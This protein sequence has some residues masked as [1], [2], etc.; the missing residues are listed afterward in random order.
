[1]LLSLPMYPA[2]P[3]S[4]V[5]DMPLEPVMEPPDMLEQ[6]ERSATMAAVKKSLVMKRFLAGRLKSG[7][8]GC[9]AKM[10]AVIDTCLASRRF[11]GQRAACRCDDD[12]ARMLPA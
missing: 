5:R 1:M 11:V 6:A 7:G 10:R 2:E 8:I 9:G 4:L 3:I 12:C